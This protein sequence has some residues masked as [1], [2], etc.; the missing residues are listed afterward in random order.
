MGAVSVGASFGSSAFAVPDE[1]AALLVSPVRRAIVDAIA[2]HLS[3]SGEP[4]GLTA[5]QLAEM[6]D[7]HVTT[8]RFHLD[9]LVAHGLLDAEFVRGAVGRP[10]KH[11][12]LAAGSLQQDPTEA[13]LK[14]LTELLAESFGTDIT[15]AAAGANW[16]RRNIPADTSPP[17]DTAGAWLTKVGRMIDVLRDWGYTPDLT[18]SE[19]GRNCR[20]DLVRCP[21]LE[22]AKTNPAVVCGIHRGLIAGA[23]HQ[24]GETATEVSLEPFVGPELCQ[25]HVRTRTPFR[26]RSVSPEAPTSEESS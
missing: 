8:V 9:Q 13:G 22:L 17:A 19:G 12:A 7:L 6:L 1:G 23:M 20:V 2:N 10:S 11:Y 24:F 16:A 4:Q 15:P 5:A 25:A 3:E 26:L 18:T 21:F 14:V